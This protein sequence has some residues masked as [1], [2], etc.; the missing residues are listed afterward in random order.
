M[1][2]CN[3]AFLQSHYTVVYNS[4]DLKASLLKESDSHGESEGTSSP[5]HNISYPK[6]RAC[7]ARGVHVLQVIYSLPLPLF[8]FRFCYLLIECSP[9][10]PYRKVLCPKFLLILSLMLKQLLKLPTFLHSHLMN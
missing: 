3:A 9:F 10:F 7:I 8:S 4:V 1:D 2:M 5:W 6:W